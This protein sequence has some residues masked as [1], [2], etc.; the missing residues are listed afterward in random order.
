MKFFLFFVPENKAED[1]TLRMF[2][3]EKLLAYLKLLA[4][5]VALL[6]QPA[7]LREKK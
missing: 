5:M 3:F 6:N 1:M 2:G 4:P 7:K